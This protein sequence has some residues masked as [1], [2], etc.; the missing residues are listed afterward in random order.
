[1]RA[2]HGQSTVEY[3]VLVLV[4]AAVLAAGAAGLHATG[5]ASAL[6]DQM[7]RALCRLDGGE[8]LTASEPC[9]V[10]STTT[11]DD[12]SVRLAIVRLRGGRTLLRERRSDGSERIT[13]V[14]RGG[15]GAGAGLGGEVRLG[16]W[17]AGGRLDAAIEV[18]GGRGRVWIV[19]SRAAGD[20]L[21]RA[22][23]AQAV[24]RGRV[25]PA[26]RMEPRRE[27][28]RADAVYGERGLSTAASGALQRVGLSLEAEDLLT[29]RTDRRSGERTLVVRRRN[30]LVGSVGLIGSAGAEGGG[31]RDARASLVLD[32]RGRP[33]RLVI[34][35]T[36]RLQGG[37][38]LPGALRSL[39]ARSGPP[40]RGGHVVET[41]R[42]L[43]LGDPANL[44]AASAFV[45]TLRDPDLRAGAALAVTGALRR[46]LDASGRTS[47]RV[48]SLDVRHSGGRAGVDA[49]VGVGGGYE[50]AV[51]Q[52]R[53]V[54]ASE[55]EGSGPWLE[56]GDC[57]AAA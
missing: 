11:I 12:L 40:Q 35:E 5:L 49:G 23:S 1:M 50:H 43:D 46:R 18:R 9:V 51:E 29:T 34:A 25:A 27:V 22:L 19:P 10:A 42:T 16:S 38:K 48:Y 44:A 2:E 26:V 21:L 37:V 8:C 36:R 13:L 7:R 30:E 33:L 15:A 54:A 55:R 20:A 45:R 32:A 41:E 14:T 4:A 31:R 52:T 53:L 3:V 57:L 56:R 6:I 28:P 47:A 17:V 39:V 24:P